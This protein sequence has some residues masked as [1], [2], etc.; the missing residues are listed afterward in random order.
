MFS[1]KCLFLV[2]Y[3]H[4]HRQTQAS[5]HSPKK[6]PVAIIQEANK[7]TSHIKNTEEFYFATPVEDPGE[8]GSTL[9]GQGHV[10]IIIAEDVI[11]KIIIFK[12]RHTVNGVILGRMEC[13]FGDF[14][15]SFDLIIF[16][17]C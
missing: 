5:H 16:I 2:E 1:K 8:E 10:G 4:I 17:Y 12:H 6:I 3:Q 7:K 11:F 9:T 13:V 14:V 15:K